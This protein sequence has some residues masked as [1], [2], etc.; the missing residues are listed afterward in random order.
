MVASCENSDEPLVSI[1]CGELK[2]KFIAYLIS[3]LKI[4]AIVVLSYSFTLNNIICLVVK[5]DTKF[6]M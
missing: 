5:F 1:Q 6:N 2:Q 3:V 4:V